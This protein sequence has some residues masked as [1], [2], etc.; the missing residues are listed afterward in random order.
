MSDAGQSIFSLQG[1]SYLLESRLQNIKAKLATVNSAVRR[2][3]SNMIFLLVNPD[4]VTYT[5]DS[6]DGGSEQTVRMWSSDG[7]DPIVM[8]TPRTDY[9]QEEFMTNPA[10]LN[11]LLADSM[12]LRHALMVGEKEILSTIDEQ[13]KKAHYDNAAYADNHNN[14]NDYPFL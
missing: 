3:E 12:G 7:D 10:E 2:L 8:S 14:I 5:S 11:G 1:G 9:G 13:K 6:T 4:L